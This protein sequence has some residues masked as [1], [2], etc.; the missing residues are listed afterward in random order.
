MAHVTGT[1]YLNICPLSDITASLW[2]FLK[3][4]Y[5]L[6]QKDIYLSSK[7]GGGEMKEGSL[8]LLSR[9]ATSSIQQPK[10]SF[11]KYSEKGL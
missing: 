9:L 2:P 10:D 7:V 5:L 8:I 11:M 1:M 4:E 3:V 6:A